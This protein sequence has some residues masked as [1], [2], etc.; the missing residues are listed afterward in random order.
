MTRPL[1]IAVAGLGTVGVGVLTLLRDNAEIVTARAGRPIAVTAVS[2]RDRHK[3]RGVPVSGLHWHDDPVALATDPRVDV[4]VELIGGSEGPA[5]ALVR[6]ALA[7]GKPVVTANKALLAVH[8]GELAA[9][10]ERHEVALAFEAAVAGGIPAI[11]ALR[12]GLAGNR[13]SRVAGIL[14]GTCN[15]IL[16]VMRD[17]GRDFAEVL[18]DAQKLGYAEADPAFDV[19]GIDAA[20]K[21]SILAALAFGRPVA[22]DDV[23]VEGIRNVSALDIAFAGE[24]GYRIK[25]L[26]IARQTE[27]GIE[28]RVHPCMI[29]EAAPIARVDGVFNAVVAEA[30]FAG[31]V[32]LQGRGAGGGPTASAVVADLIDIARGRATPVWGAASEALSNV[33]SLPMAAHVGAYYLRLMVVDRP[34]VIADVTAVLRDQGISL[35]SM[36]QRGRS[37]GEAVPVVMVTH[38]TNEAAM[39]RALA[40]ISELGAVLEAPAMIRIEPG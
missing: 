36:L 23:F 21:L 31:R 39:R 30:D 10:A 12:E 22:F 24:L 4:V 9:V 34:G 3:D 8:G 38:E 29:P 2:S 14:N 16:T 13:I 33:P 20:H 18:A 26:G 25:L 40:R 5:L 17:H 6:A 11:K 15:Y 32:M 1:S 27:A 19:D 7:A 35:E 28:A 37:P